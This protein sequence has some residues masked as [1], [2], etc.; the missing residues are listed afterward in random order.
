MMKLSCT[1]KTGAWSDLKNCSITF[2]DKNDNSD[3]VS[4][5]LCHSL[6]RETFQI[7]CHSCHLCHA[8]KGNKYIPLFM[9]TGSDSTGKWACQWP[10]ELTQ[11]TTDSG[12]Q[13]LNTICVAACVYIYVGTGGGPCPGHQSL[14]YKLMYISCLLTVTSQT[15]TYWYCLHR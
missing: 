13:C 7:P 8:A 10:I 14:M 12:Y 2:H 9:N 4:I 3:K 5:N 1:G 6:S 15:I 11:T